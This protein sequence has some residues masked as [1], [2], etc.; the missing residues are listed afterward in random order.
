MG[1]HCYLQE[2]KLQFLMVRYILSWK[3]IHSVLCG[4]IMKWLILSQK[5]FNTQLES[6]LANY[7]EK[8]RVD[9]LPNNAPTE[10]WLTGWREMSWSMTNKKS[11]EWETNYEP[12][13]DKTNNVAV[14]PAKTDQPGHPPS[15]IRSS[16]SAWR[17]LGSLATHWAHS[18]DSDQT[19]WMPRLIWVFAGRTVILL[20]LSWGGS[21]VLQSF[22]EH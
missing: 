17:K 3:T 9:K 14:R 2:A 20:V 7:P 12:L 19:G 8:D 4:L 15:L 10:S 11:T 16:L 22:Q 21:Y 18:E 13:H 1:Q 6:S 5:S